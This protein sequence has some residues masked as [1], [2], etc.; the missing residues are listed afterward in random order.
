[1]N[2]VVPHGREER[3]KVLDTVL[4]KI[5]PSPPPPGVAPGSPCAL[6]KLKML[7]PCHPILHPLLA[8]VTS[9]GGDK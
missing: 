3:L 8:V 5:P 6:R 2:R 7:R 4:L 9:R 1:M